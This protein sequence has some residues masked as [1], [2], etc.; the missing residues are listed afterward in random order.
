MFLL[1]RLV[2]TWDLIEALHW[3]TAGFPWPAQGFFE[4]RKTKSERDVIFVYLFY[5]FAFNFCLEPNN[6]SAE[7]PRCSDTIRCLRWFHLFVAIG[8]QAFAA[9]LSFHNWALFS[10]P[11][12]RIDM[13]MD[14]NLLRTQ[15]KG[16]RLRQNKVWDV[17]HE[18]EANSDA[19]NKEL[20]LIDLKNIQ[21][22][23]QK[24]LLKELEQRIGQGNRRL[25][26]LV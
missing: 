7:K 13:H 3:S 21:I 17:L 24:N 1:D 2:K 15:S 4:K 5:V 18:H 14:C 22:V 19:G 25:S 8:Q 9:N 12:G 20:L 23:K 6:G 11:D 26:G 16:R 10:Q